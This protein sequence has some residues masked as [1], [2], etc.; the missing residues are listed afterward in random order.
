MNA[1]FTSIISCSHHK[2]DTYVTHIQQSRRSEATQVQ[3]PLRL[4][5]R[6][7]VTHESWRLNNDRTYTLPPEDHLIR[8]RGN[9]KVFMLLAL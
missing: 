9:G 2:D 6:Y 7:G 1:R 3:K 4:H 8:K 5:M